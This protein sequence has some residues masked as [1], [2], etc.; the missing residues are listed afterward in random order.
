[1]F[2]LQVNRM[3]DRR[4]PLFANSIGNE[5]GTRWQSGADFSATGRIRCGEQVCCIAVSKRAERSSSHVAP[6]WK[7]AIQQVWKPALHQKQNS[8]R[9]VSRGG[10]R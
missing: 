4:R 2:P 8:R 9:A 10:C 3:L 5:R 6:I 7:S 1:M